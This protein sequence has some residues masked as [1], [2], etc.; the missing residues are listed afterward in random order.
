MGHTQAIAR[1]SLVLTLSVFALQ[2]GSQTV[3][4]SR[5]LLLSTFRPLGRRLGRLSSVVS[6]VNKN[7]C[8]KSMCF[9][10]LWTSMA[11]SVLNS[12]CHFSFSWTSHLPLDGGNGSVGSGATLLSSGCSLPCFQQVAFSQ[13]HPQ[14]LKALSFPLFTGTLCGRLWWWWSHVVSCTCFICQWYHH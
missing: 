2:P 6:W 7:T 8:T 13:S 4:T 11:M 10:L 3:L 12:L 14:T 5:S 9:S 1:V